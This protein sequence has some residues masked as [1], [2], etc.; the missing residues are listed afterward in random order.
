MV[1]TICLK[2]YTRSLSLSVLYIAAFA[3]I[4]RYVLEWSDFEI[5]TFGI[6]TMMTLGFTPKGIPRLTE[7]LRTLWTSTIF[8]YSRPKPPR[9]YWRNEDGESIRIC[10]LFIHN[11]LSHKRYR[12]Y[13]RGAAALRRWTVWLVCHIHNCWFTDS[14][15]TVERLRSLVAILLL[16]GE[17]IKITM[18]R[19]LICGE[20]NKTTKGV[21]HVK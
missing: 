15:W 13:I 6:A 3:Y 21:H 20:S 16:L 17:C 14:R 1:G 12:N 11:S 8:K 7:E 18:N 4:H 2:W 9:R 19:V 10:F 5:F